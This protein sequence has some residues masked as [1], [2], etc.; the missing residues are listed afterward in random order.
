M[1]HLKES[2]INIVIYCNSYCTFASIGLLVAETSWNSRSD[3]ERNNVSHDKTYQH[4]ENM[5][6]R[7]SDELERGSIIKVILARLNLRSYF[8]SS[9]HVNPSS[10]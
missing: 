10:D 8:T 2:D 3:Q 1:Y 5:L 6:I 4:I 7:E 9:I